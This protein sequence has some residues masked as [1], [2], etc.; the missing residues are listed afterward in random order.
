MYLQTQQMKDEGSKKKDSNTP[1]QTCIE[2]KIG[3]GRHSWAD[4]LNTGYVMFLVLPRQIKRWPYPQPKKPHPKTGL[5][6]G[7]FSPEAR[8]DNNNQRRAF[9]S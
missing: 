5:K 1:I 2:L 8:K 6:N 3:G 7:H 9:L 4:P